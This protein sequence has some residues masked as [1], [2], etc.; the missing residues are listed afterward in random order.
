MT[1]LD[2]LKY[3]GEDTPFINIQS[4]NGNESLQIGSNHNITWDFRNVTNV[5][6]DYSTNNGAVWL[7]I[8]SST[9]SNG[10]Y[11]WQVPKYCLGK[12]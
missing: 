11:Q 6:I 8:V 7:P 1:S 3:T 9:I 2:I 12:L 10:S 5:K 4:P